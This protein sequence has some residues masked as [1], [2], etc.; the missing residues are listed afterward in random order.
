MKEGYELNFPIGINLPP[1]EKP[2]NNKSDKKKPEP[3]NESSRKSVWKKYMKNN[4]GF[5]GIGM[6]IAIIAALIV[7]GGAVYYATKTS[8]PVLQNV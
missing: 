7:G 3:I 8:T 6:I 1:I 2:K 4:K 5:I